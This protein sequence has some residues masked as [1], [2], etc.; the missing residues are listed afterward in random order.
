VGSIV[1]LQGLLGALIGQESQL[2]I[3]A[4]TLA[5]AALFNPLR[6]R[7][8]SF[9]DRSFYRRRYDARKTLESFSS[10]LRDETDL[11]ALSD[12][13]VGVVK[14][15]MQPAHASLW[16]RSDSNSEGEQAD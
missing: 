14:E 13:L 6:H 1:V 15:T 4:S 10:T 2:A 11:E 5:V 16:L 7:I 9:I 12:D 8:Q 3:V